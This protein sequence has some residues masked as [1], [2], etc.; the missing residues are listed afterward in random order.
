MAKQ[1]TSAYSFF[2]KYR[3]IGLA[4]LSGVLFSLS[5]P[6]GGVPFLTFIAFIPLF[7]LE[8]HVIKNKENHNRYAVLLYSWL[9]FGLFNAFTTWWIMF[10][11]IPGVLLAVFLNSFFM[12][13]PFYLMH[14]AR[15][16]LP[17]KQGLLSLLIF[18]LSFEYLHLDWDLSWSWL[19]LGNVFATLPRWV[20][21]YEYTGTLGGTA[22]IIIMNISLFSL[23]RVYQTPLQT[24]AVRST[25]DSAKKE[26]IETYLKNAE[27]FHLAQK[28]FIVGS[29]TFFLL[30]T[31]PIISNIIWNNHMPRVDPVEVLI[32]QPGRDPYRNAES[33]SQAKQWTDSIIMQANEKI[34]ADTRFVITPEGSLPS[35]LWLNEP[36][37]HYGYLALKKHAQQFDSLAWVA[38]VMMY[39]RYGAMDKHS[40]TARKFLNDDLYYDVYNASLFVDSQGNTDQYFKSK[41]VPGI[42]QMPFGRFLGPVGKLVERFGGTAGSMGIQ[43]ERSVFIHP[44]GTRVAPVICYESVY[45]AYLAAYV[46]NGAELIFIST[47]DGWWKDTPGYKQ[48]FQYARLRAVE[49]R[50]YIA[51]AALTGISG[52]IDSKGRVLSETDWWTADSQ[53]EVIH[54]NNKVTFYVKHGDYIGRLSLFLLFLLLLYMITQKVIKKKV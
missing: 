45:G 12:A 35:A 9:S 1:I 54:K 2:S 11:S 18:W 17:G 10:A 46:R 37:K 13:I 44:D 4:I 42:E 52:F 26:K 40:A 49:T 41:L 8:D 32:V 24:V 16:V 30:I 3:L 31:P 48:H 34:S 27:Q 21:W 22:W 29:V 47:N 51:R 39:R 25:T 6:A 20:Q 38:G 43:E 14:L 50:R 19:N 15:R 7:I 53:K 23:Y 5:W 36:E 33:F 28:R